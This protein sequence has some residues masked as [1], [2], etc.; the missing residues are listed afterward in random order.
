MHFFHLSPRMQLKNSYH[1]WLS[2]FKHLCT[3]PPSPIMIL[4]VENIFPYLL[5]PWW[6]TRGIILNTGWDPSSLRIFPKILIHHLMIAMWILSCHVNFWNFLP[7]PV[8]FLLGFASAC[9]F[10]LQTNDNEGITWKVWQNFYY[11]KAFNKAPGS[12]KG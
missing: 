12:S 7:V 4:Y 11:F 5:Y 3:F 8:R 9:C 6:S 2:T 10:L 1:E